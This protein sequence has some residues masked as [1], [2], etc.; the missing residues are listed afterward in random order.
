[1]CS[2]LHMWDTLGLR[3]ITASPL[4]PSLSPSLSPSP[5][6]AL[7]QLEELSS[8]WAKEP[9]LYISKGKVS[10]EGVR[11]GGIAQSLIAYLEGTEL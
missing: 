7:K 1:M 11:N 3:D 8:C 2:Q 5:Q 9:N 6:E 10:F 4:P